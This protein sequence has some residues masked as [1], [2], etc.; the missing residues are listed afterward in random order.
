M[1]EYLIILIGFLIVT[2]FL[3]YK[4]RLK[5]YNSRKER[6]IIPVFFFIIATIW[7]HFAVYRGHWA[8]EGPG[9]IGINIGLIPLEEYLFFLIIPYFIITAY[10]VLKREI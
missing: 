3:E 5:L 9:L 6:V 8:F 4:Y 7:D 10:K 2:L 1:V